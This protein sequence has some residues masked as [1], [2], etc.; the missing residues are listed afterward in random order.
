[1]SLEVLKACVEG[2]QER[3]TD[4]QILGV[5]TGFWAGYYSKAKKPKSLKTIINK[6]L[7]SK[8]SDHVDEA[9]DVDTFLAREQMFQERLA[10][11]NKT[12]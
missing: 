8:K 9:P 10:L 1:M 11:Q 5:H 6:M 3:L 4:Q 2:Y 7:S 12:Q